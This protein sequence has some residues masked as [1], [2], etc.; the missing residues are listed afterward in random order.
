MITKNKKSDIWERPSPQSL[1]GLSPEGTVRQ[2]EWVFVPVTQLRIRTESILWDQ[3]LQ[4]GQA[5]SPQV[6][7]LYR[8]EGKRRYVCDEYPYGLSEA[9]FHRLIHDMPEQGRFRWQS[10][11]VDAPVY[12]KGRVRRAGY[13][14]LVLTQWHHVAALESAALD[15]IG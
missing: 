6:D 11:L 8:G 12:V 14:A 15:S 2:G 4:P 3:P 1:Q 9:V 5:N 13:R 7:F 10:F